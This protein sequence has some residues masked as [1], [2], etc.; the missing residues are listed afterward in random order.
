MRDLWMQTLQTFSTVNHAKMMP[1]T[2]FE[3]IEIEP[4]GL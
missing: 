2:L 1:N 3:A 4:A